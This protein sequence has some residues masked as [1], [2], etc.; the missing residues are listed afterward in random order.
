MH[1]VWWAAI[2]ALLVSA[3]CRQDG[4]P[5]LSLPWQRGTTTAAAPAQSDLAQTAPDP[6]Q[7]TAVPGQSPSPLPLL[8]RLRDRQQDPSQFLSQ[9]QQRATAQSALAKQQ[10][11]ELDRL[12]RMQKETDQ[13]YLERLQQLEQLQRQALEKDH[14]KDQ[15]LVQQHQD[16]LRKFQ[17]LREQAGQLDTN[18]RDLHTQ[19][20][21]SQQQVQLL[22]DQIHLLQ[23]R[24]GET[25]T[26]LTEA[27]QS[28]QQTTQRLT[29]LQTSMRR[30]SDLAVRANSSLMNQL[31]A[32]TI[33]GMDIRQD[34]D[35]VR[36]ALPSDQLFVGPTATL[37]QASTSL[38]GQAADVILQHYA[39]QIV[40]VEAHWDA[41][42]LGGSLW[43]NHHQLT[44]AQA[45]A[46]FEQLAMRHRLD[47]RQ[48]F[49]LGHGAN[50]P[51]QPDSSPASGANNRRVELVIYPERMAG[52]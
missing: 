33:P 47:P 36:I 37:S 3:G 7:A 26:Q 9:L 14:Q 20:A 18:N 8:A 30:D 49:V 12:Q 19:L 38:L 52:R 10:R 15:Q 40:G 34:Q 11:D 35:L 17:Q 44:A 45:M 6:A 2:S 21:H 4:A 46:V 13:Q 51:R 31:T 23:Q 1:R 50:Q 42:P 39:S 28:Q 41:A 5:A 48:L 22:Q 16:T 32:V 27:R 24:L 25:V 29:A 43:R